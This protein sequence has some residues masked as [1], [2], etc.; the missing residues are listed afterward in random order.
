MNLGYSSYMNYLLFMGK[1]ESSHVI[2]WLMLMST[3]Y[4]LLQYLLHN[5]CGFCLWTSCEQTCILFTCWPVRANTVTQS[6]LGKLCVWHCEIVPGATKIPCSRGAD[7][8][9][10]QGLQGGLPLIGQTQSQRLLRFAC[11][12]IH[13]TRKY[14][15]IDISLKGGHFSLLCFAVSFSRLENSFPFFTQT[16]VIQK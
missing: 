3:W 4:Y 13:R 15:G 10:V 11:R 8:P 14:S 1:G 2:P 9:K 5:L 16:S 6:P 7:F 12:F